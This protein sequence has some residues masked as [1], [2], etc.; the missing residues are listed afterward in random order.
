[1]KVLTYN[2]HGW[3]APDGRP[4]R[5]LVADVIAESG[6]DLV[7]LNEVFQPASSPAG[8]AVAERLGMFFAFGPTVPAAPQPDHPPYGNAF[9]SRWPILAFAAHHL[10]P[11]TAYGQRGLLEARVLPPSGHSFTVYITHLDHRSE[12]VRLE[13]WAAAQTWLAR[14]RGRPHLV[15][16]DFNALAAADYP[17]PEALAGLTS[18]QAQ[19]GWPAPAFDLVAQVA[20]AGYADAA[21]LA[22]QVAAP[23]YPAHDPERRIDY[24]FLPQTWA[25]ALRGC[26]RVVTPA[27]MAASDHL[28]V[29]AE[30]AW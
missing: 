21:Q 26:W 30:F 23:T 1:M 13:Q 2:V 18:Y 6:A 12:A 19:R 17:T 7:G 27:A 10:T 15:I 24:I 22:G 5:D 28:P 25:S 3:Q 14:D 8:P 16:G 9:L 11:K 4:N 20:R 29:L